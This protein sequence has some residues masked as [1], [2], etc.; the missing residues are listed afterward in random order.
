[1]ASERRTW[2][3]WVILLLWVSGLVWWSFTPL[4]DDVPTGLVNKQATF[5]KFECSAP[6]D[7]SARPP[8]F[9]L[10]ELEAPRQY[11]RPPCEQTHRVNRRMMVANAV[12]IAVAGGTLAWFAIR[13]RRVGVPVAG[14]HVER[15]ELS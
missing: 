1:M 7:G 5:E 2:G 9:T 3:R 12:L 8:A 6:I 11:T 15:L 4:T 10:P 13:R 14:Q